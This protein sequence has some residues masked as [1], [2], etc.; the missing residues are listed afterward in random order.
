MT[1]ARENSDYTGLAADLAG[2]QTNITAG[3]I[4]ARAGRKNLI[5]NG[6]MKV[7]QRP[8]ASGLNSY[9]AR[10]PV[11]GWLWGSGGAVE[12]TATQSS[13]VPTG[14]GFSKSLK[15]DVTTADSSL[16]SGD[17]VQ[18][19][20]RFEGQ[21]LQLMKKGTSSAES[22]T[23]SFWIKTSVT[24]TYIAR[25]WDNEN[26]S[27]CI[28]KPYTV[29]VANTWE[30]KTVVFEG[31]TTGAF[32]SDNLQRMNLSLWFM[33]GP[34]YTSGTLTTTWSPWV[35]AN[36]AVGQVNAVASTSN[37]IY[38]TGF[39]LETGSVATDF[40]HLSFGEEL[41]LCYRYFYNLTYLHPTY[42]RFNFHY[43]AS[44]WI[45]LA[46]NFPVTMR[47]MATF[48]H[49]LTNAKNKGA[50]PSA[51]EDKW[52][53]YIQNTGFRGNAGSGNISGLGGNGI[54][55]GQCGTVNHSP[56]GHASHIFIGTGCTFQFSAEL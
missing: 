27:R 6:E 38:I 14:A 23:L 3:D 26:S 28:Q 16:V 12:A 8:A 48:S 37:D 13:D 51:G 31:D 45:S 36:G 7:A 22:L 47:A 11:D 24:G 21:N 32:S 55:H 17:Y 5:L 43:E 35:A 53:Y 49:S 41:R 40:E 39:Q 19:I 18:L 1:K 34:N 30:K 4:A 33:A 9:G 2:L 42:A 10:L 46:I 15:L 56:N 52:C 25:L 20:Q 54:T 29:S 44:A 50:S